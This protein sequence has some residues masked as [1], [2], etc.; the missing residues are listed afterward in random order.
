MNSQSNLFG[1]DAT[2][3]K[4]K[5]LPNRAAPAQV[6]KLDERLREANLAKVR[7]LRAKAQVGDIRMADRECKNCGDELIEEVVEKKAAGGL[8][9][10]ARCLK[11]HPSE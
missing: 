1:S 3:R 11:C 9:W 5:A 7:A 10:S 4:A 6:V 2:K 8:D